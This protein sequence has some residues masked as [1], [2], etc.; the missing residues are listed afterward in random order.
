MVLG[1]YNGHCT[2]L[3]TDRARIFNTGTAFYTTPPAQPAAWVGLTDDEQD[4]I[5]AYHG[6]DCMVYETAFRA[7]DAKLRE[8]NAALDQMASNAR[9]LGLSYIIPTEPPPIKHLPADDTEG[10][11]A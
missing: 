11:A 8:K 4:E 1:Y 3:P 7:I 5:A 10:G 6:L 2:I 9:D